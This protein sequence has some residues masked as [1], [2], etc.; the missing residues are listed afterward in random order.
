M[1]LQVFANYVYLFF[2]VVLIVVNVVLLVLCIVV[3]VAYCRI[4]VTML[5]Y[6]CNH[7]L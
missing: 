6:L 5:N 7:C 1:V 4:K 2:A 3:M